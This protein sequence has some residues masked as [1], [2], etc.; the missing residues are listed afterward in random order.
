MLI[1]NRPYQYTVTTSTQTFL[2][3]ASDKQADTSLIP[4]TLKD[5]FKAQCCYLIIIHF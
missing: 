5:L 3:V 2:G 1:T 4:L